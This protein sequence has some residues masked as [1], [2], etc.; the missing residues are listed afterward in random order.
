[1]RE[2][3]IPTGLV[4]FYSRF[5]EIENLLWKQSKGVCRL[6][7]W[8][9]PGI[10]KTTIAQA[11]F[12]LLSPDFE[13]PCFLKDFHTSFHEKGSNK[14]REDHRYKVPKGQ[15]GRVLV[16][17]DDVRNPMDA[18]SFL[19]GFYCFG[20]GSVII[21]TSRDKQVLSQC[22]CQVEDIYTVPG[23]NQREALQLFIRSAFRGRQ[24]SES[25]LL[26]LSH[27]FI[28]HANGNPKA[29]CLYGNE[30]KKKRK[31]QMEE[32]FHKIKE[33]PPMEIMDLFKSSYDA[34]SETERSIFLDIA[35]FFKGARRDHVMRI[36]EG[37]AFFP[38]VGVDHLADLS[39]LT[40]SE[41]DR[42][43]MHSLVQEVGR[44]IAN[45]ETK[46]ISRRRRLWEPSDIKLLLEDKESKV[47]T[48]ITF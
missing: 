34:L 3:L 12:D 37:C 29:L 7:I 48:L 43:E 36:L 21:I 31:A 32:A 46:L 25:N 2:K 35:C 33:C 38:H 28:E 8:G 44:E 42:V 17:L 9:M 11:A 16:V 45:S 47:N 14:L 19:G 5:V 1:M 6:G 27:K 41:T 23:L 22:Q 30:L 18:E 26:D 10:G 4:R 24:P 15:K 40:M 13:L 20:P 39:L